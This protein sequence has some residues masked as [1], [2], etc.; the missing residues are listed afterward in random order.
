MYLSLIGFTVIILMWTLLFT[1]HTLLKIKYTLT[2]IHFK[3]CEFDDEEKE[4]VSSYTEMKMKRESEFDT[5]ISNLIN[6]LGID[7]INN[8]GTDAQVLHPNVYNIPHNSINLS[9]KDK[10]EVAD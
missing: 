9:D 5:R 10:E 2:S 3:M 8:N 4:E 1:L 7:E 6:E